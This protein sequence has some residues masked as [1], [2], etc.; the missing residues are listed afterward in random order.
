MKIRLQEIE[1]G[2]NDPDKSKLFYSTI[3]GLETSVDQAGLKVFNS[4][5]TGVDF[6]MSTHFPTK[7]TVTSFLTDNLQDV[8]ERLSENGI[9][10][11][12]PQK[13]HLGMV[14]IEFND[15]D[16]YL[17]R[18]NQPTEESPTWLKV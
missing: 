9:I 4:G 17:I 10:F 13:S 16:G 12:G 15:P 2:T 8:I 3:L 6:N 7:T 11:S 1:L 5:V 18:V 14:S